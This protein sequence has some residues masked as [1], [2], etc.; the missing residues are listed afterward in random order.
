MRDAQQQQALITYRQA[1]LVAFEEVEN[2]IIAYTRERARRATLADAADAN[3][4]AADLARGLYLGG[5]ADFRA[6][7]DA[8]GKLYVA[9]A[10]LA[11]SD[12]ALATDLVALYKA[13]GGGWDAVPADSPPDPP[14]S[15]VPGPG[16]PR[17]TASR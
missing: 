1:L 3:R 9:Q 14:C 5:L 16:A 4:R 13:L 7:L 10:A 2:A 11:Q 6:V 17:C 12:A 8:Q 15:P